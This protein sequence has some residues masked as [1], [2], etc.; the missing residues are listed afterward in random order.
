MFSQKISI[1]F[2]K[3]LICFITIKF[4]MLFLLHRPSKTDGTFRALSWHEQSCIILL[5]VLLRAQKLI[6]LN[7][8]AR[9]SGRR[10]ECLD[11]PSVHIE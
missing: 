4:F 10:P 1:F 7:K 6:E 8:T 11:C 9:I 5:S 3:F 2:Q